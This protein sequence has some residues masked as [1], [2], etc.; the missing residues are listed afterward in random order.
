MT[1]TVLKRAIGAVLALLIV[2]VAFAWIL[3]Q[4]SLPQ[5]DG[6]LVVQGI[7]GNVTVERDQQGIPTITADNRS[8]L[9]FATGFVHGQDR[10][11]Q[12]DLMRRLAAGEL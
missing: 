10:F 6:T 12:M 5:L 4:R 2:A 3:L 8:D 9:A 11:F 7:T 1:L